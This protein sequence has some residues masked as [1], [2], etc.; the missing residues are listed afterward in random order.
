MQVW[1]KKKKKKTVLN[2]KPSQFGSYQNDWNACGF[3]IKLLQTAQPR[4]SKP[5]I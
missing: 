1:Q 4:E 2:T 5:N 3:V